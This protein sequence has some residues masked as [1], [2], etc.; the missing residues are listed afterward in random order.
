MRNKRFFIISTLL[1]IVLFSVAFF[2]FSPVKASSF[3][4]NSTSE[5]VGICGTSIFHNQTVN[6]AKKY[7][8]K[9]VKELQDLQGKLAITLEKV[10]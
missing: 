8:I 4:D 6:L 1:V 9:R 2:I 7:G 10:W 3:E 5:L